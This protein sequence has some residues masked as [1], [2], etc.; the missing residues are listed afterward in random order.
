MD[1]L[2]VRKIQNGNG[3]RRQERETEKGMMEKTPGGREGEG[4][5]EKQK[6]VEMLR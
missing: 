2:N 1:S 6:C 5:R 3:R 4:E